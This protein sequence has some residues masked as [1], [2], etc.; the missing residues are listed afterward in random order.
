MFLWI[1]K[2]FFLWPPQWVTSL[3]SRSWSANLSCRVLWGLYLPGT[4]APVFR[5]GRPD[6][7]VVIRFPCGPLC[8]S[9]V[10]LPHL[11]SCGLIWGP[12]CKSMLLVAIHSTQQ[13]TNTAGTLRTSPVWEHIKWAARIKGKLQ[14]CFFFFFFNTS[15]GHFSRIRIFLCPPFAGISVFYLFIEQAECCFPKGLTFRRASFMPVSR[16]SD[17]E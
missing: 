9:I 17:N 10:L 3:C 1:F 6:R 4:S 7:P 2:N 13:P 14:S 11:L 5:R 12:H 16:C 15:L 8:A